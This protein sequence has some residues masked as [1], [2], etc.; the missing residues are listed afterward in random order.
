MTTVRI[1]AREP[2]GT[3]TVRSFPDIMTAYEWINKKN[4]SWATMRIIE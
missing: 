4:L 2:H 1:N 3:I